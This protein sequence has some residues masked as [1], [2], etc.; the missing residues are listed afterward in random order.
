MPGEARARPWADFYPRVPGAKKPLR[1]RAHLLG[2]SSCSVVADGPMH[3]CP[4]LRPRWTGSTRPVG[5]PGGGDAGPG[6]VWPKGRGLAPCRALSQ[7]AS[8]LGVRAHAVLGWGSWEGEQVLPRVLVTVQ[9]RAVS[10]AEA[11]PAQ[12]MDGTHSS[13]CYNSFRRLGKPSA[14]L[15]LR[16]T[17]MLCVGLSVALAPAHLPPQ[18][19]VAEGACPPGNVDWPRPL[20]NLAQ[21][22]PSVWLT[23]PAV[24][25]LAAPWPLNLPGF[26]PPRDP[27]DPPGARSVL[28][29]IGHWS[30]TMLPLVPRLTLRLGK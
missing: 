5:D 21:A 26:S 29:S 6:E 15:V 2:A 16:V 30:P 1:Q 9:C 3:R 27:L 23:L 20:S 18:L 10:R 17:P 28:P 13:S 19:R 7:G 25:Q 24:E 22:V 14:S 8:R 11:A 12:W 4:G